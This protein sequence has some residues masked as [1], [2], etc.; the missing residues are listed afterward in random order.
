MVNLTT[1]TQ[2]WE[3]WPQRYSFLFV[4]LFNDAVSDSHF[5]ASNGTNICEWWIGKDLKGRGR[6]LIS[7]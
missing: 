3:L 2:Q 4:G 1:T 7:S 5:T 6:D